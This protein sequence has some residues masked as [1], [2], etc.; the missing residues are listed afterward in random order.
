[1]YKSK[2]VAAVI[3]A[4]GSSTRMGKD[5]LLMDL[6]GKSVIVRTVEAF[7][8]C[9]FFDEIIVVSSYDNIQAFSEEFNKS[10]LSVKLVPGGKTRGESSLNGIKASESDYVLIHDGAR[11]LVTKKIIEETLE[12]CIKYGA[13]A[14]GVRA[15][16]TIKQVDGDL[17]I[18]NTVPRETAMLIQTPQAFSRED[19]LKA[20]ESADGS[21]TDDCAVAEKSGNVIKLVEGSYENLKLTTPED[22][23]TA[24]EI[25]SSKEKG[26]ASMRIGTG[27]DTHR[28]E[29]NRNLIIGGVKIP[30]EKGLLG[31]SDADVLIHAVIDALFGAAALGDIGTHFPDN[32]EKYKGI[33]SM[34]LLEEAAQLIEKEGY[35]VENLDATVIAQ[36]PKLAPYITAMRENLQGA[37]GIDISRISV[38]AKTNEKM[39]FTGRGEG[40]EARAVVL[41]SEK[42]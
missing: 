25:I 15:K 29:E 40:V 32:D 9:G 27:F 14:T 23:I 1:M 37:L 35:R 38:K 10:N 24:R 17:F 8:S 11:P 36:S 31:H 7:S 39:G 16:D 4:G 28:L 19:I 6:C 20:Y 42:I 33:S 18:A 2:T 13:A 22:V 41:L 21:E 12:E 3:A 26:S 5:K 34:L 30:Y